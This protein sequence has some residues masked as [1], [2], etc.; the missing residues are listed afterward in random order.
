[1]ID[2]VKAKPFPKPK[3]KEPFD[4]YWK[5]E[6]EEWRRDV[7]AWLKLKRSD[8]V[9]ARAD[10]RLEDEVEPYQDI[11]NVYTDILEALE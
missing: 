3:G 7:V 5:S 9:N 11:I 8:W 4:I 10:S 1:M 6:I 2:D